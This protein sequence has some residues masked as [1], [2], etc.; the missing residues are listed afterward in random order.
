LQYW[1]QRDQLDI[2]FLGHREIGHHYAGVDAG[3]GTL[4]RHYLRSASSPGTLPGGMHR[5]T[6]EAKLVTGTGAAQ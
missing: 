5:G 4:M 6:A 1:G 2:G 3:N